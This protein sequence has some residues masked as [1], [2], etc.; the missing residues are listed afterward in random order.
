MTA[1]DV[2]IPLK[3]GVLVLSDKGSRGERDD[4]SGP[5]IVSFLAGRDVVEPLLEIL[6]DDRRIIARRLAAWA[7][8][9]RLDVILTCGGTGVAP[10]DV[11]PEATG[12][13]IDRQVPGFGERMRAVSFQKTPSA[14]ISRA[15]AGIRGGTLIVNLPGSPRAAVENLEAVWEAVPHLV[16]KLQGDD[17]DCGEA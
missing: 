8:D 2:R 11:T 10:R 7:D 12:D 6:P 15:L 5:A 9:L 3:V 4:T 16:A 14:L 1:D 13:V 17:R